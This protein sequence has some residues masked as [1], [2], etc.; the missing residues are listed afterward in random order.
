[1][2]GFRLVLVGWGAI[3]ARVGA[4]LGPDVQIVGVALRDPMRARDDL[5]PGAQVLTDPAELPELRPDLVLEV[6]GCAAVL[7]WG[8]AAFQ[9]GADFAPASIAALLQGDCLQ[10]LEQAA[11]AA[12]RQVLICPGAIGGVDA[13]AAASRLGLARVTHDIVKPPAAWKGTKAEALCDLDNLQGATVFLDA[14]AEQAAR[15]FPQNA[16][17]AAITSLAGLGAQATGVR[18]VA[19]PGAKLNRHVIEAEGDFG[20]LR[21]ELE[22]RPLASNPKS[23]ELTALA[24]VRLIENRFAAVVV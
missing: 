5:P 10:S 22:N 23:S 9:A 13:L 8:L 16:N 14:P 18:L 21:I 19:D 3:G 17:V 11:R 24:L 6:A 1:M 20:R 15:D 7:P 2:S 12:G 4:V